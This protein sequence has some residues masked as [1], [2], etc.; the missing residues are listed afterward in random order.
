MTKFPFSEI[1]ISACNKQ[2]FVQ[3]AQ[4]QAYIY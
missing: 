4:N 1:A 2:Y 3:I